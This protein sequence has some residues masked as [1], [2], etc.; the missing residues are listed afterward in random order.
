MKSLKESLGI[1]AIAI[2]LPVLSADGDF[3]GVVD[4]ISMTSLLWNT[5]ITPNTSARNTP[6]PA[7]SSEPVGVDHSLRTVA[8][9]ARRVM[10]EELAE[11]DER[12][13][14]LFLANEATLDDLSSSEVLHAIKRACLCG[15]AVPTVC[16]ASLKGKGIQ[17]LLNCIVSFLPSPDER[18]PVIARLTKTG[19]L[20]S[21][22]SSSDSLAALAFKVSYDPAR[23]P[24]VYVR[25][26]SGSLEARAIVYNSTRDVRE[27]VGQILR[28]NAD[29]LEPITSLEAG[30]VGCIVGLKK[31]LSGDTLVL[32]GGP[33][34]RFV[35]DGLSIPKSVFALAIEPERS[36]QQDD[37]EQA[38]NILCME[39]PSLVVDANKESGQMLIR[40]LGELHL[41]IVCDKLRR[42]FGIAVS[43]GRA[44]VAFRET[45]ALEGSEEMDFEYDKTIGTKRLYAH[46]TFR[47]THAPGKHSPVLEYKAIAN[48]LSVDEKNSLQEAFDAGTSRGPAGYPVVGFD[49]EVMSLERN[50]H[51]D[52]GAVRACVAMFLSQLLRG[53]LKS[54]LQPMMSV[55]LYV[56][57]KFVGE[58]LSDLSATRRGIV[59]EVRNEGVSSVVLGTVPLVTMLGYA[60]SIRSMTQ[61]EG[62]FSLE[63]LDHAVVEEM[64]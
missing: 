64:T 33:L 12:F 52:S 39:D 23:G 51:T 26:Y 2:Q 4:L 27:R 3:A 49:V 35:L 57:T 42:Q 16:G 61:G 62:S 10:L 6:P 43:T 8:M 55:E 58:V 56:P 9:A 24:L 18:P 60:S 15:A 14:D 50:A 37:L 11:V 59:K 36:S 31:T 41:E 5:P 44:Y 54:L 19:E 45:L 32:E 21:I 28:V 25:V 22:A 34:G 46:M 48:S 17:P 1:A 20:I 47:V 38:L 53:P 30:E 29:E 7:P 13:L 63:Y 40:G